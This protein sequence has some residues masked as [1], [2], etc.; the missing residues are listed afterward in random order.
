VSTT[1]GNA[2]EVADW[3]EEWHQC[4]WPQLAVRMSTVTAQWATLAIAGPAARAVL[5]SADGPI[6]LGAEAFPHMAVR[7]GT[8][9]GV[10]ARIL[11]VSYTGELSFEVSVPARYGR[12]LWELLIERGARHGLEPVGLDAIDALRIEK[13]YIAIGHDT[14]GTVTPGDLGMDWAVSRKKADFVGKRGMQ[15]ADLVRSGRKQLVGLST[16]APDARIR[17]GSPIVAWIDRAR[18]QAPPVPMLGHVTSVAR[19][20]TLART[21]ALALV[22]SGRERIGERIAIVDRGEP[23][24]ASI[25]APRFYDIEGTRL[26]G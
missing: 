20:V 18:I 1:S 5:A 11:R 23:I 17:E 21:V 24:E 2:Q 4:E 8:Y 10:P 3:L 7:C 14:D 22:A 12:A 6:D 15:R 25:V 19:S 13:G 16:A 26:H 9:A